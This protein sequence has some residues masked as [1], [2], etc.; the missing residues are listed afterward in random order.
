MLQEAQRVSPLQ[1]LV[2]VCFVATVVEGAVTRN[3]PGASISFI[4]SSLD[5]LQA[6]IYCKSN[7]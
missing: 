1:V 4:V 7:S 2:Q 5:Y 3:F 6:F